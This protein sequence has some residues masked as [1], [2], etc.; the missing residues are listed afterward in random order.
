MNKRRLVKIIIYVFS[1]ICI[2]PLLVM[3]IKSLQDTQ[4]HL[5]MSQYIKAIFFTEDFFVGYWNSLIYTSCIIA[6][7][8]PLSVLAAYGFSRF[9]FKGKRLLF[10]LYII[11]MLMPF[12][13]T[14]VPQYL[15]LK[16][17]GLINHPMA[18]II[19]NVFA[20]FGTILMTQYMR[21]LDRSLYDA[22]MIDGFSHFKFFLKVI[23]PLCKSLILALV[24]LSF[25][26]YW[27]MIE[28]PLVF[29]GQASDMPLAVTM[30]ANASIKPVAFAVGVIFSI[31]PI[32]L[33]QLAYNDLVFGIS[34]TSGAA[35]GGVHIEKSNRHKRR[36]SK[37]IIC[38]LFF[39]LI[40]SLITNKTTMTQV[41][42]VEKIQSKSGNLYSE[43]RNSNSMS[44]G[45]F[46]HILPNYSVHSN[47]K[48]S[49]VYY[50]EAD[51]KDSNHYIVKRSGVSIKAKND[52]YSAVSGN[53][54]KDMNIVGFHDLPLFEGQMAKCIIFLDHS[55]N[56]IRDQIEI[57][58]PDDELSL[59]ESLKSEQMAR[60]YQQS[61]EN[62]DLGIILTVSGKNLSSDPM[63]LERYSFDSGH[64]NLLSDSR[65]KVNDF[66][67]LNV[68]VDDL[69]SFRIFIVMF[70]FLVVL[71]FLSVNYIKYH[72]DL[73]SLALK[74]KYLRE[75][76]REAWMTI[77]ERVLAFLIITSMQG[78]L[79][80]Q[81][82]AF[83]IHAS[84]DAIKRFNVFSVN[85]FKDIPATM[86][87]T[88]NGKVLITTLVETRMV[89]VVLSICAL[90]LMLVGILAIR[91][92]FQR[93]REKLWEK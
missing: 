12:Q 59:L 39:M 77:S 48:S 87:S 85:M 56:A 1:A 42:F 49:Y 47:G 52:E 17:L 45:N 68:V 62:T 2:F 7:N 83:Q 10:L 24:M 11:L 9:R 8:V 82:I 5:S 40:A 79:V 90:L 73:L 57:I 84:S 13:A 18:I 44:M 86:L 26:N 21:G 46:S 4:G 32:L 23:T 28:Q 20:T 69:V 34:V 15:T 29:I 89:T 88:S 81:L 53:V 27:S 19:P 37:I 72:Y 76:V 54:T 55:D 66:T 25:I 22:G 78:I 63:L 75:I 50:L 58:I 6:F 91:K 36:V 41:N 14:I 65:I 30:N 51:T 31:L 38:F 60:N 16:A 93:K 80:W 74:E 92:F 67:Q 3:I 70:S 61:V 64:K 43:S 33:Y 35:K 71:I